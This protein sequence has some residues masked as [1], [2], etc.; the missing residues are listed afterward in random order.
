MFFL[1]GVPA[2]VY[3]SLPSIHQVIKP[4]LL[5]CLALLVV[6]S[7]CNLVV[8]LVLIVQCLQKATLT[9]KHF[10]IELIKINHSRSVKT[11]FFSWKSHG[12]CLRCAS[13]ASRGDGHRIAPRTVVPDGIGD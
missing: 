8:K 2:K 10:E 13:E 9:Q 3:W 4:I 6:G 11:V 5:K 7:Y 12:Q 1:L